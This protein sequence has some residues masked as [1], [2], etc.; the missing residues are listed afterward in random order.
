MGAFR[1]NLIV[2]LLLFF[3][4]V[5]YLIWDLFDASLSI[6]NTYIIVACLVRLFIFG[7][8]VFAARQAKFGALGV[9]AVVSYAAIL[10]II[11]LYSGV[12]ERIPGLNIIPFNIVWF[13]ND[14]LDIDKSLKGAM[15][16]F[17]FVVLCCYGALLKNGKKSGVR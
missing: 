3:V 10:F 1:K 4:A 7:L 15:L 13:W 8:A 6:Q 12:P 2:V 9:K 11:S 14:P 17:Y 5:D 16:I